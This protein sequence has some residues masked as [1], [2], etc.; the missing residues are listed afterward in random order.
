MYNLQLTQQLFRL[1]TTR[2]VKALR[3]VTFTAHQGQI[4]FSTSGICR[5]AVSLAAKAARLYLKHSFLAK[6][7]PERDAAVLLTM[8]NVGNNPAFNRGSVSDRTTQ[9]IWIQSAVDTC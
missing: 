8:E 3:K 7:Y 9:S 5:A 4:G 6:H 2:L 1:Y